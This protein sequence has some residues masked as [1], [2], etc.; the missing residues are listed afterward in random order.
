MI[1][2]WACLQLAAMKW[3]NVRRLRS[4][5]GVALLAMAALWT[6]GAAG[7]TAWGHGESTMSWTLAVFGWLLVAVYATPITERLFTIVSLG[8]YPHAAVAIW[9]GLWS[10]QRA[11]GLAGEPERRRRI[12]GC[13]G[14]LPGSPRKMVRCRSSHT[15]HGRNR[16]A[17]GVVDHDRD[18]DRNGAPQD[19]DGETGR[20]PSSR[21]RGKRAR[22]PAN[23][24]AAR[25]GPGARR[26]DATVRFRRRA[27]LDAAPFSLAPH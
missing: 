15:R 10:Q 24:R 8:A 21:G 14:C 16:L 2:A 27:C 22:F 4:V 12:P 26:D 17:S 25:Y 13:G 20:V 18:A 23:N 11:L 6:L 3:G 5:P 1:P 7:A 19:A 9:Q